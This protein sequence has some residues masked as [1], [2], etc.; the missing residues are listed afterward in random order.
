LY[1]DHLL[2]LITVATTSHDTATPT[3]ADEVRAENAVL[4]GRLLA[5]ATAVDDGDLPA[6][7]GGEEWSVVQNIAHIAEFPAFF[8]AELQRFLQDHHS[9]VGRTHEHDLRLAAV[10]GAGDRSRHELMASMRASF[11][12][13]AAVLERLDD[14][15]LGLTT[16]NRKYGPEP[17]SAFLA[18]Y[19]LD[20]KRAH[21]EQLKEAIAAVQLRHPG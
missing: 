12:T 4:D 2:C 16:Q 11:A 20:H 18:R 9:P 8:A 17:L 21:V 14:D 19:V 15:H 5:L 7:P 10:E 13:L 3:T 6:S 1:T